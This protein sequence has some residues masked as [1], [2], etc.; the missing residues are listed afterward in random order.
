MPAANAAED[1]IDC[2]FPDIYRPLIPAALKRAYAS[3]DLAYDQLEFMGT[4]SGKFHRGDL[5]QLA[6]EFEFYKLIKEGHLPF[7]P[8]WEFYAR[9]TGKHLVMRSPGA[10][11]TLSQVEYPHMKP[12]QAVFRDSMSVPNCDYLFPEWNAAVRESVERKH[13]L[14]LHGHGRLRFSNLAIPHPQENKLIWYTE[15]LLALPHEVA[16]TRGGEGP[17]ESPDAEIV[18][19]VI[20]TIRDRS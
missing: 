10:H 20:R 4:P 2:E 17:T 7:D 3:A 14:L 9:P 19:D 13:V 11:I 5:I 12:R 15:D 6:T 18:D 1:L 8:A 16:T